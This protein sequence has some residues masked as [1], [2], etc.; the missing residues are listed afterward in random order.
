MA[1]IVLLGFSTLIDGIL[2]QRPRKA[3]PLLGAFGIATGIVLLSVAI[4]HAVA[5]S[6]P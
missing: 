2:Y 4:L 1:L 5:G 6:S 3:R